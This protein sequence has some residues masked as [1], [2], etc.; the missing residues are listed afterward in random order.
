MLYAEQFPDGPD[1]F[2]YKF[3]GFGG[4]YDKENL[5]DWLVRSEFRFSIP[6]D[7]NDPFDFRAVAVI[8]GST[9]EFES[10][11]LAVAKS[12]AP[13]G[14]TD[15]QVAAAA[16][17]L[18]SNRQALTAEV[19]GSFERVRHTAGVV[20]FSADRK[21]VLLWS[22]YAA[23]H[24]GV[25]LQI[26]VAHD[27]PTFASAVE[28]KMHSDI[29]LPKLNWLNM[30][31]GLPQILFHKMNWWEYENERRIVYDNQ[32]GKYL[33]FDPKALVRVILGCN[34]VPEHERFVGDLLA[35]R[36]ANGLPSIE[37]F[38]AARHATMAKL[39]IGRYNI[40]AGG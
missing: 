28:V 32:G 34:V 20:C 14:A 3:Y 29:S 38:R 40:E 22:H 5:R 16:D 25:C 21:P 37:V 35:E 19:Q 9:E 33:A 7:F 23:G 24:S 1:R 15:A 36:A 6:A 2:L 4:K 18:A 27:L 31:Q 13:P 8:E 26:D 10:R 30:P 11:C 39:T 12:R 17:F